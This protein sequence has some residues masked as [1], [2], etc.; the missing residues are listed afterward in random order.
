[1]SY[2]GAARLML[3]GAALGVS[4]CTI[5]HSKQAMWASGQAT[6][7][8]DAKFVTEEDSGLMLLGAFELAEPDHYAVLL[9][10]ARRRYQCRRFHHAQLDF[11]TD[12][13]FIISFPIS[14]LTLIC[15]QGAPT[16]A[17]PAETKPPAPPRPPK[18]EPPPPRTEPAPVPPPPAAPAEAASED[19]GEPQPDE[20]TSTPE[21]QP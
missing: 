6:P 18:P 19:Q 20:S 16:A 1:M 17:Q 21:G 8:P 12:Y 13:W 10:R 2:F 4:G 7:S 9:E 5:H 11:Y 3:L 15:E 14:R